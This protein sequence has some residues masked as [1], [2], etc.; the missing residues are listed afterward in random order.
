MMPHK[1]LF[2]YYSGLA[3]ATIGTCGEVMGT[4]PQHKQCQGYD[5]LF[6][7][8]CTDGHTFPSA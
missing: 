5:H 7:F 6:L 1:T 2:P 4:A 3:S 8:P